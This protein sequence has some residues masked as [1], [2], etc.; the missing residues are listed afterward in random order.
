M[1]ASW[2]RIPIVSSRGC[3]EVT[4]EKTVAVIQA[5]MGSSRL[6]GKVLMDLAGRPAIRWVLDRVSTARS[7]DE[8]WLATSTLEKDEPLA[9][10]VE[11]LGYHVLRGSEADVLSRFAEIAWHTGAGTLVR[12]TGDCP[13]IDPAVID[14]VVSRHLEKRADYT[15]NTNPATF[16]DGLDVE[17]ISAAALAVADREAADPFLREH[18]T[19]YISAKRG[20][21]LPHG[22]FVRENI[23]N[24]PDLSFLRLTLDTADDLA[25]LRRIAAEISPDAPWM[26]IVSV[27]LRRPDILVEMA[28]HGRYDA[29]ELQIAGERRNFDTSNALF[30]RALRSIPLAS[31][32][33]SKSHQQWV[34]GA[35]PLFLERGFG[36]EVVDV[37]GNRYIDYVLG[38]LPVVLGYGDPDVDAAILAQLSK[39]ISFSLATSLE[40]ELSEKIVDLIPSAEMVRFGKNGSDA[41]SAAIRLARAHTGRDLVALAG[42]HGWHDWYIGTTSRNKGVPLAVRSLSHSFPFNDLDALATLLRKHPDEFAAIVLEPASAVQPKPGYLEGVR[43]LA[44]RHGA[45][46]VFDE[47]ISGFRCDLGGAQ[48]LQGV[49]PDLSC[50]GKAMA[51][52]MPLSAIVGRREIMRGIEDIFFSGTFGGEALSLAAAIATIEKLERVDGIGR[53]KQCG[54]RLISTARETIR[55]HG[56]D[57]TLGVTDVDWWPRLVVTGGGLDSTLVNSLLRQEF[58]RS[59]LLLGASF[60]LSLSHV[61]A[62]IEARTAVALDEAL[63][64]VKSHLSLPDPSSALKGDAIRPTFAVR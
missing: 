38:L 48:A 24:Q 17:V 58:V 55:R 43:S 2:Y 16:P 25:F 19:P 41:T 47:I 8:I 35:S 52:G 46:L 7:I 57:E 12:I 5:R 30:E 9:A 1:A 56:L 6:P 13:F 61:D 23:A 40:V 26:D 53:I 14:M 45:V 42:Y 50:F 11:G 34:R 3:D 51:N 27:L 60:N 10:Y 31:Q 22:Q 49:T 54:A 39:G 59:G 20:D 4:K 62:R 32:T 15:T 63:G 28:R 21:R 44:D 33:F 37:D 29:I 64:R 18:V 36:A